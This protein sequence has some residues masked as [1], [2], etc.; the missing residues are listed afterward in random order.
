VWFF[1]AFFCHVSGK[2]FEPYLGNPQ[3][4]L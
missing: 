3:H 2:L 4:G 1:L